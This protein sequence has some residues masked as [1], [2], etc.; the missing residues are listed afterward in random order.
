MSTQTRRTQVRTKN[1]HKI[2][3]C[4]KIPGAEEQELKVL[5]AR[6][7]RKHCAEDLREQADGSATSSALAGDFWFTALD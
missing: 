4:K 6:R 5:E 1:L 3:G 7:I 2:R